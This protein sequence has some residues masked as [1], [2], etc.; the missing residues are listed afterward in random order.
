MPRTKLD[1]LNPERARQHF[2]RDFRKTIDSHREGNSPTLEAIGNHIG[3]CRRTMMEK[4][5]TGKV[6]MEEFSGI[7]EMLR[8][9]DQEICYL[10]KR[11]WA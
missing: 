1:R 4:L 2:A 10:A 6:T 5:K 9:T 11:W 8:F 7:A 3:V